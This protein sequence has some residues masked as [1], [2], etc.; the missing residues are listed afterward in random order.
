MP[1]LV[2]RWEAHGSRL[3][4][5]EANRLAEARL[6]TT[7]PIVLGQ[8]FEECFVELKDPYVHQRLRHIAEGVTRPSDTQ[9]LSGT[10]RIPDVLTLQGFEI[11]AFQSAP[12][13]VMLLFDEAISLF[14]KAPQPGRKGEHGHTLQ[15]TR[16]ELKR[17][18]RAA[19]HELKS[20]LRGIRLAVRWLS[21][22]LGSTL[23]ANA[24]ENLRFLETRSERL[25]G[26]IEGVSAYAQARYVDFTYANFSSRE[27]L[28][29]AVQKAARVPGAE[30]DVRGAWGEIV[31][32]RHQFERVLAELIDNAFR[33]SNRARL[34]LHAEKEKSEVRFSVSDNGLGIPETHREEIFEPFRKLHSR[35]DF[36]SAGTGLAI[37]KTLVE[38]WGGTLSVCESEL[39]GS[40]FWFTVPE[41]HFDPR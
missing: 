40:K 11:A 37:C 2:Y 29:S 27:A 24:A 1:Y 20:P 13:H 7:D 21:E 15:S 14:R 22:E 8:S 17:F 19:S 4:L 36:D 41:L 12:N 3:I 25:L 38:R 6:G 23:S 30:I 33:F 34:L 18:T 28:D 26:L 31:A 32:D 9:P 16:A 35:D 5:V 39:G 10:Q